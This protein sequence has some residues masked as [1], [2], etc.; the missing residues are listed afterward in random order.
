MSGKSDP[1]IIPLPPPPQSPREM[2]RELARGRTIFQTLAQSERGTPLGVLVEG[3]GVGGR[4][5]SGGSHSE[6]AEQAGA[7][8]W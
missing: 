7:Q 3:G 4:G 6:T 2:R 1:L 5:L 8:A